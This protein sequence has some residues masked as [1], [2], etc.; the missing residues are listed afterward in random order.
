MCP[1]KSNL[2]GQWYFEKGKLESDIP[3]NEKATPHG[4]VR[5]VQL[6]K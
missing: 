2:L 6:R 4:N 5:L 3:K 1:F